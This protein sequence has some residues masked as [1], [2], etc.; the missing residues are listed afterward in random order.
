[1]STNRDTTFSESLRHSTFRICHMATGIQA[2]TAATF[3]VSR[4]PCVVVQS[5]VVN[6]KLFAYHIYGKC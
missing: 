5:T 2:M 3:A 4:G 6:K 1:M